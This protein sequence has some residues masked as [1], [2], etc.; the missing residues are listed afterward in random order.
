M[1]QC[2]EGCHL[3]KGDW[4][5][6]ACGWRK[7]SQ[8][9]LPATHTH[10]KLGGYSPYSHLPS[11]HFLYLALPLPCLVSAIKGLLFCLS[12]VKIPLLP[13]SLPGLP[14]NLFDKISPSEF[15]HFC[16]CAIPKTSLATMVNYICF[17]AP[18]I[19]W[20]S[21]GQGTCPIHL[22]IFKAT[23]HRVSIY[24]ISMRWIRYILQYS[25]LNRKICS[26]HTESINTPLIPV[27]LAWIFVN[28]GCCP[29]SQPEQGH[30]WW[31]R[32]CLPVLVMS[33]CPDVQ[34]FPGWES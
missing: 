31:Q 34:L 21:R 18:F 33:L 8:S 5:R 11:H 12:P 19:F 26:P 15:S 29:L 2:S 13:R 28:I 24:L 32:D 22:C 7:F 20:G 14:L 30:L 10:S 6:Q 25:V 9:A 23:E 1:T 4:G 3:V 27:I 17:I 16:I